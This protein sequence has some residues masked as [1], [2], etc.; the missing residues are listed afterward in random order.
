MPHLV[1]R[2]V[3]IS[4]DDLVDALPAWDRDQAV[5]LFRFNANGTRRLAQV[6][7]DNIGRAVAV[8][9]DKTV[10]SAPAIRE[11]ILAGSVQISGAFTVEQA[12]DLALQVRA[13]A[14]P[15]P[16]SII[17]ERTVEPVT[18]LNSMAK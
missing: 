15:A 5:V 1:S 7:R 2:Q 3:L 18:K 8:V 4:G 14:L 13:G 16:L 17:E 11:P 12:N 9:L 6:T 10:L